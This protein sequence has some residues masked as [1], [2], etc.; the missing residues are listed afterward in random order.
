VGFNRIIVVDDGSDAKRQHVFCRIED[1]DVVVLHHDRNYGKGVAIKTALRRIP[2]LFPDADA[3]VTVDDDGQHLPSDVRDVCFEQ[4]R[5]PHDIM[6][7]ERNLHSRHVPLRSRFGNGF[8]ALYFKLDTGTTCH[9]TQTGLRCIPTA[10]IPWAL[11]VE[12]DRYEYEMN[13]L[14]RAVKE[15]LGVQQTSITTVYLNGN[16]ESHF[17]T[18]RDS[19]RIYRSFIRFALSSMSCA[20][21]D[22]G[23]FA[24]LT[25]ILGLGVAALVIVATFVARISSGVLNFALNRRW[26]FRAAETEQA[27]SDRGAQAVRYGALFA[28]Q[29]LLSMLLVVM[30]SVLPI[31]LVIVK[32]IVDSALF[33]VS[34]FVQRNW[35]FRTACA[36][37][38]FEREDHGTDSRALPDAASDK[39]VSLGMS[40]RGGTRYI[41]RVRPVRYLRDPQDANG[42]L[43]GKR[44]RFGSVRHTGVRI[45]HL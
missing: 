44:Q 17:D 14:T 37:D 12:G 21:V 16:K 27:G 11:S 43:D 22:L 35:V 41:H 36:R 39:A 26:S 4:R 20:A 18:L 25:S 34:Y 8:S 9:D 1:R 23:L 7:G 42:G 40:I 19:Y 15:G 31:P 13:L 6:L 5:H 24:L 38:A 28:T 10:M 32:I 30:L 29:M 33:I 3:F 2:D 45:E